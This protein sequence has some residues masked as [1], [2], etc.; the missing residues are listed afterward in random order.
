ME[1]RNEYNLNQPQDNI[2]FCKLE[3]Y[4]EYLFGTLCIPVKN[5]YAK[6]IGFAFYILE[7]CIIFI[8]DTGM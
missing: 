5:N 7:D 6:H 3:S 2:H 8:D 4:A 1:L